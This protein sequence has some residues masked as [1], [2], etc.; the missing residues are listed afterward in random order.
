M[1]S[2]LLFSRDHI[3]QSISSDLLAS[4]RFRKVSGSLSGSLRF[5]SS[6]TAVP[7]GSG[8]FPEACPEACFFF[9]C[10]SAGPEDS[11][12]FPE[13]C[14][15]ACLNISVYCIPEDSGRLP[16]DLTEGVQNTK[17]WF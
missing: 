9:V 13:A 14:P 8:R 12:R 5:N 4:G 15:E 17:P 6:F 2:L 16:E 11:G 1:L 3:K 7:E 10:V